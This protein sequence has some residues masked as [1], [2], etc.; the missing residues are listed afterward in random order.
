MG[1]VSSGSSVLYQVLTEAVSSWLFDLGN[2]NFNIRIQYTI[3]LLGS[4]A[5]LSMHLITDT[6]TIM[7]QSVA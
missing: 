3:W 5:G 4:W 1:G 7:S 6:T 2:A